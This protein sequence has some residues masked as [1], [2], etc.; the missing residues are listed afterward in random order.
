V[1]TSPILKDIVYLAF[2]R[3]QTALVQDRDEI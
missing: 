1:K 2:S 3:S